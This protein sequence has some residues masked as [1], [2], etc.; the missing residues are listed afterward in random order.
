MGVQREFNGKAA[1]RG[2]IR[3]NMHPAVP[4]PRPH[5]GNCRIELRPHPISRASVFACPK[6]NMTCYKLFEVDGNWMCR[7]CG[8][9]DYSCR[10][11][12][13]SIRG[14]ARLLWLRRRIG[15][16]QRPFAPLPKWPPQATRKRAL[17]DEIRE[18]EIGLLGHL[19][20]VTGH[21]ERRIESR[22]RKRKW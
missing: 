17:A 7:T 21:L 3:T 14:L 10:H 11:E 18:L 6:C 2:V 13:R 16:K 19:Q 1:H 22:K 8:K 5:D 15:A 4:S 12:H 20:T 9:L